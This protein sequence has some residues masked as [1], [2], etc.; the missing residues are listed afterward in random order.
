[1][2]NVCMAGIDPEPPFNFEAMKVGCLGW[3]NR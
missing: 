3:C 2:F 1:L